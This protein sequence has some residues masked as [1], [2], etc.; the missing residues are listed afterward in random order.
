MSVNAIIAMKSNGILYP[1][2]QTI[3]VDNKGG[4]EYTGKILK[5][6]F[7]TFDNL[8]SLLA[9]GNIKMLK[10]DLTKIERTNSD[11][12]FLHNGEFSD[13]INSARPDNIYIFDGRWLHKTIDENGFRYY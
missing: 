8:N 13:F 3:F 7:N 9:L 1:I 6:N 11:F 2:F 4:I 10:K 5:E 12:R